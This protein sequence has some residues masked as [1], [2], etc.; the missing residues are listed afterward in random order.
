MAVF[1][2]KD[3]F[4]LTS[5][6][7]C[8]WKGSSEMCGCLKDYWSNDGDVTCPVCGKVI[9]ADEVDDE[10]DRTVRLM[11]PTMEPPCGACGSEEHGHLVVDFATIMCP[12]VAKKALDEYGQRLVAAEVDHDEKG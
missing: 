7:H 2:V 10:N 11:W 9:L 1:D 12:L 3:P 4:F 6:E 5:C 8:G